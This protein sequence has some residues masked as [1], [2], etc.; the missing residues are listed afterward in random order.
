M[1]KTLFDIKLRKFVFRNN[2]VISIKKNIKNK[3]YP[4]K[5]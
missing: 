2:L 3:K 4:L 5:I 1:T